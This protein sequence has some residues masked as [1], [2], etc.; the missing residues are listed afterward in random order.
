MGIYFR[1]GRLVFDY[2]NLLQDT[3]AGRYVDKRLWDS[4]V[5]LCTRIQ[6]LYDEFKDNITST[7]PTFEGSIVGEIEKEIR[8]SR[9]RELPG[10][11]NP[12]IFESRVARFVDDWK[13]SSNQL[14][15]GARKTISE[16]TSELFR[17]LAPEFSMLQNRVHEIVEGAIKE[18]EIDTRKEI[19]NV[20]AREAEAFTMNDQF[21][22]AVNRK[23]LERFDQ[24]ALAALASA[25]RADSRNQSREKEFATLM[26]KWV[27]T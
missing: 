15:V 21:L 24:A 12:R 25:G 13:S 4:K 11:L 18:L 23:R 1:F 7:K 16:V 8:D 17:T 9:G 22:E 2:H 3:S 6:S 10:F 26:R 14:V 27:S 20:F 5:R 19:D